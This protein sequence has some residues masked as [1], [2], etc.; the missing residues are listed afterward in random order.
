MLGIPTKIFQHKILS[1]SI[2]I[3]KSGIINI[4]P[5]NSYAKIRSCTLWGSRINP[6]NKM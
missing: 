1:Q 5:E 4:L 2:Y 3:L 6:W